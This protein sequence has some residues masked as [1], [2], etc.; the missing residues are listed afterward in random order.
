[1]FAGPAALVG[2]AEAPARHPLAAAPRC[3]S[4]AAA[5]GITIDRTAPSFAGIVD[6][7]FST[8]GSCIADGVEPPVA[9]KHFTVHW[10]MEREPATQQGFCV[11]HA[12]SGFR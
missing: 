1:M 11:P 9:G 2:Q 10:L 3:A 5:M 7:V 4:L 8:H 6:W 12:R